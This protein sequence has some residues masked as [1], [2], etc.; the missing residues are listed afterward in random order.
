MRW[1]AARRWPPG[2]LA[3]RLRG[4]PPPAIILGDV[5]PHS[6]G[7]VR[8]LGRRGIPTLIVTAGRA[9][10]CRSRYCWRYHAIAG[11]S[12]RLAFL[13]RVG[14][15]LDRP[16]P[17]VAT[18]DGDL[19]FLSRHREE[20]SAHF[21]FRLPP[22]ELL[23]RLANKKSQY[24]YMETLGVPLPPTYYP[25]DSDDVARLAL[26]IRFPC[27]VKPAYSHL[28][29]E[30]RERTRDWRS[31]K[32]VQIDG[33]AQLREVYDQASRYGV[34]LLVQERIPGPDT[35]LYSLYAYFDGR[36][37]PLAW[38]VIQ[39]R[40]QWPPVY[41]SGSFSVTCRQERVVDLGLAL[42]GTIGYQGV[43]NVEFKQDPRDGDVK[44]IEVNARGGERM[45]LA[46]AAGVDIPH[47]AYRDLIGEAPSRLDS[48]G[49]GVTWVNTLTDLAAFHA[50]YRG[51]EGSSW[52]RW[53]GEVLA[54][55]SHAFLARDDPW[56][57]LAQLGQALG[58]AGRLVRRALRARS[59][60]RAGVG[61][62]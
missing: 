43:A 53:L 10:L 40:R 61:R 27:I 8:S 30:R 6:L 31:V 34:E 41:G 59:R 20:L 44:L 25:R 26:A 9:P 32:A 48:Y 7:F 4:L 12:D 22:A 50:Y 35:R 1:R 3:S 38:C 39:K 45:A 51:I 46:T 55:D 2:G 5:S 17:L 56:P 18:S 23:E 42:L 49:L 37:Q 54:A 60:T 36:S 28:W 21:R 11:E 33:A 52:R 14:S 29:R 24:Q 19:L 15:L 47:I 62:A 16:A 13:R 58:D 57:V